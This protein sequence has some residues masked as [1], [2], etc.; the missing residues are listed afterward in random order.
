MPLRGL[1]AAG[2]QIPSYRISALHMTYAKL[3]DN[4]AQAPLVVKIWN[5]CKRIER[6]MTIGYAKVSDCHAVKHVLSSKR[7]MVSPAFA[8]GEVVDT[9][10]LRNATSFWVCLSRN[11]R[12]RCFA[13]AAIDPKQ[14]G[15]APQTF[16]TYSVCSE[17]PPSGTKDT[18]ASEKSCA[19]LRARKTHIG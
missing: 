5:I 7:R 8:P 15:S 3:K 19:S 11:V 18:R 17:A 10:C 2:H 14:S 6:I 9:P 1:V 4:A 13:V 16:G 12:T